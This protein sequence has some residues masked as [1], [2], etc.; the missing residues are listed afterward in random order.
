[1]DEGVDI[2]ARLQGGREVEQQAKGI[3]GAFGKLGQQLG[4]SET[5][6]R[7]AGRSYAF[8]TERL[9]IMGHAA[10]G[11]RERTLGL[12][13][14]ALGV[15]AGMFGL[16]HVIERS[17]EAWGEQRRTI[18]QT[19]AV[20]HSTHG[21]ANITAEGITRLSESISRQTGL[22]GD[23]IAK[24]ENMMLTFRD[25]RNEAGKNNDVFSQSIE[26]AVNMSA[27][28]TS[29]GKAMSISDASLQLGKALNDPARGMTRLQR[30]GVVFT[31]GQIDQAKA[32]QA[33]GD[34]LGAQRIILRELTKEFGGSA[35]AVATPGMK[36]QATVKQLEETFGRGL[37]PAIDQVDTSLIHLADKAEPRLKHFSD[38]LT[39]TWARK[40]L[41]LG[42]KLTMSGHDAK[43][44]LGPF[45]HSLEQGL[46]DAHLD[47]KLENAV[48][49]AA[50]K[51]ADGAAHAAPKAAAAFVHAW[52]GADVWGKLL[53][54]AWLAKRVGAFGVVGDLAAN[55]FRRRFVATTAAHEAE[56]VALGTSIGGWIGPA[57]G[58]AVVAYVALK[59]QERFGEGVADILGAP[60]E[61]AAAADADPSVR[62]VRK[63]VR[64]PSTQRQVRAFNLHH[65]GLLNS[66]GVGWDTKEI[67][68]LMRLGYPGLVP[69]T[70]GV[71][72]D[73]VPGKPYHLHVHIDGKQVAHRVVKHADDA[74]ARR[75]G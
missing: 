64:D 48:E 60:T 61:G 50:P 46:K 22:E 42:Q 57:A 3:A 31:Q 4:H 23:Q 41:D 74:A 12:G 29:A 27:A 70:P 2:R 35:A 73:Y 71:P 8:A 16:E 68:K 34:R 62:K 53:T 1:M 6:A 14:A 17:V 59:L 39:K 72:D 24:A 25:V 21:Q 11:V 69:G 65:P 20:L 30:I 37:Q 28:F 54:A 10:V 43:R 38:D 49:W 13:A 66:M 56:Y 67:A 52:L 26:A 9:H 47:D 18:A 19:E 7:R 33:S 75:R 36:L 58:A 5:E 63:A 44:D 45:V 40:D 32:L 55:R 51:I 15:S